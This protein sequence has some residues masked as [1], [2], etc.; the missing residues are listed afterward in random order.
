MTDKS[1]Y[2]TQIAGAFALVTGGNRGF[3]RAM[4]DEL[5]ARGAAKV[6]ATA[7]TPRLE[8][9]P[10]I[11]ALLLDVTDAASVAAAAAAAPDV[12]IVVSNAG[13]RLETAVLD[14]N[15]EDMR[16]EFETNV[17]GAIR[18][19]R[20]FAPALARHPRSA[21]VSVLS[22]ASWV[23]S[24]T[25]YEIAKAAAW[26]ATNSLRLRLRQQGTT[27][28]AVHVSYMDTDATAALAVP[29]A[30]PR[31]VAKLVADAI[32]CGDFE[33]LADEATSLAK[34]RLCG[35]V[36]DQYPELLAPPTP[37]C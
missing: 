14:A 31:D 12:S 30:N 32:L 15:I 2:G 20:A 27:V 6:Y 1:A 22:R 36:V 28:S 13:V 5:L 10:R 26:S 11:V 8:R 19:A 3:G 29:K 34:S 7:R 16:I 35:E 25:G 4:V 23:A 9:D 24:G 37:P 21:L 33:I 18:V 17:L